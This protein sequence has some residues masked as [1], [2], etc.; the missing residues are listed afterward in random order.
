MCAGYDSRLAAAHD[1][2]M[3]ARVQQRATTACPMIGLQ[4]VD[5]LPEYSVPEVLADKLDDIQCVTKAR[6]IAAVAVRARQ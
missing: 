5:L 6:P 3:H 2:K 4:V 1:G